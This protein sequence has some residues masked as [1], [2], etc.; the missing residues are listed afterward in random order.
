MRFFNSQLPVKTKSHKHC[1]NSC[2][3]ICYRLCIEYP[4]QTPDHRKKPDNRY[5]ADS[6]PAGTKDAALFSLPHYQ[7]QA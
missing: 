7:E 4:I 5:K 3:H 1:N 2:Q 6:L